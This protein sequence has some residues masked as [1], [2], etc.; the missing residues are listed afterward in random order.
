MCASL[1]LLDMLL[2]LLV[3]LLPLLAAPLPLLVVPCHKGLATLHTLN[4]SEAV[5]TGN[6]DRGG[7]LEW[8]IAATVSCWGVGAEVSAS[9]NCVMTI[10]G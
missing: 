9:I 4:T 1:P 2:P 8:P 6:Q 5:V 7:H 3:T 10:I